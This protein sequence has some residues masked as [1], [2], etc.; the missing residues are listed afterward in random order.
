MTDKRN[1]I[2]KVQATKISDM[3]SM[4]VHERLGNNK[5][6]N[7]EMTAS[8]LIPAPPGLCNIIAC[9]TGPQ[10]RAGP[11]EPTGATGETGPPG[12]TGPQG[13]A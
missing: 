12:A 8:L 3:I 7:S 10:G 13:P 1:Q 11:A 6:A 9:P 2:Q 4:K 5:D